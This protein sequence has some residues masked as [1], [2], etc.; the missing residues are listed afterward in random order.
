MTDAT[1]TTAVKMLR[2]TLER[3]AIGYSLRHKATV[4]ALGLRKLHQTVTL[5]DT[6]SLRGMLLMVNHLVKIEEAL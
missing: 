1:P 6:P 4:R 5:P 2:I 3:S